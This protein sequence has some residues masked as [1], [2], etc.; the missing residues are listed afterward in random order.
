MF[1][2]IALTDE[3][4]IARPIFWPNVSEI[5]FRATPRACCGKAGQVKAT[6]CACLKVILAKQEMLE[7]FATQ[8]CGGDDAKP[9][10]KSKP[11]DD[12]EGD[13]IEKEA[14]KLLKDAL[15]KLPKGLF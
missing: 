5:H 8:N 6:L 1:S 11:A 7:L 3:S 10:A 9:A 13:D 2:G 14:E 4:I 15:K 12:D